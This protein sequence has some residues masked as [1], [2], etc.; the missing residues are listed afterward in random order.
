MY[1]EPNTNDK[2]VGFIYP[3]AYVCPRCE[4]YTFPLKG[5]ELGYY[6]VKVNGEWYYYHCNWNELRKPTETE[7]K[8]LNVPL[9]A[10][11]KASIKEKLKRFGHYHKETF[12]FR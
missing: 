6:R 8:I 11:H 7:R 4:F 1:E 3:F 9:T 10:Y 2:C 5:W 12:V